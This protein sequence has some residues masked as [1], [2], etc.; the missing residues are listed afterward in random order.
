M[1]HIVNIVRWAAHGDKLP[2]DDDPPGGRVHLVEMNGEFARLMCKQFLL[3]GFHILEPFS[4]PQVTCE[5][6]G[7]LRGVG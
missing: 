3:V 5:L 2:R 7:H 4:A 6:C 1:T